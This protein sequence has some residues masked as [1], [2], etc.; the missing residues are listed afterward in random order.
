MNP[1]SRCVNSPAT[2]WT[3]NANC[4]TLLGLLAGGLAPVTRSGHNARLAPR[5][6]VG[7][8]EQAPGV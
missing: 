7:I 6:P 4:L 2:S 3:E 1:L 8:A 5:M